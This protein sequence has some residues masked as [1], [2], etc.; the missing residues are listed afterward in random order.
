[1]AAARSRR[2]VPQV[3]N[4]TLMLNTFFLT[5]RSAVCSSCVTS[6]GGTK[7]AS[8]GVPISIGL[9]GSQRATFAA[10]VG[11]S[12]AWRRWF[13]QIA[14]VRASLPGS[15]H[16]FFH[17]CTRLIS[18][19]LH[20]TRRLDASAHRTA[21][22]LPARRQAERLR[23][24]VHGQIHQELAERKPPGRPERDA[25]HYRAQRRRGNRGA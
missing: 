19:H 21:G 23:A 12:A 20:G 9:G 17:S 2:T 3:P 22:A 25:D 13:C 18:R 4:R 15:A 5:A 10:T 14:H 8:S 11:R 24:S 7:R 16:S 1:P 6:T